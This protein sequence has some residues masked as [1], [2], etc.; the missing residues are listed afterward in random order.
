MDDRLRI[1]HFSPFPLNNSGANISMLTLMEALRPYADVK[2]FSICRGALSDA[3]EERGIPVEWAFGSFPANRILRPAGTIWRMLSLIRRERF[4]LL[5]CNSAIGN[6]YCKYVRRLTG[7]PLITHQRDEYKDNYFHSD[8][9]KADRIIAITNFV[10]STLPKELRARTSVLLNPVACPAE[11]CPPGGRT[12]PVVGVMGRCTPD[13][14]QDLFLAGLLPLAA[15]GRLRLVVWGLEDN[16]FG[17][18]LRHMAA[19][20]EGLPPGGVELGGYSSDVDHFYR[21]TDI[22]VVP[23]RYREP[24]GRVQLEAMTYGRPVVVAGHAGLAETVTDGVNGLTFKPGDAGD[25]RRKVEYLI[26]HPEEWPRLT[27][28][29]RSYV[30]SKHSPENNAIEIMKIYRE[31]AA[32]REKPLIPFF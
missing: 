7:V 16:K 4:D 17:R 28:N 29:G 21:S 2:L 25:L 10:N 5:H 8:L 26:A 30:E 18:E 3:A 13:K 9:A 1:L 23:S 24:M 32:H 15:A 22:V 27:A 14:G 20:Y 11:P 19:S 12:I 31:T 6:H